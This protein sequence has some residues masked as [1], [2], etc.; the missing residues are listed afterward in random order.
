[1]EDC[2]G[3]NGELAGAGEARDWFLKNDSG[4]ISEGV[5]R[6]FILG[7]SRGGWLRKI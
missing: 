3:I 1:V 7:Y 2:Y 4:F 5:D 6:Q